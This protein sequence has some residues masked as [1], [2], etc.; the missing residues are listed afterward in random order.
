MDFATWA[1][2]HTI[3]MAVAGSRL[4]GT[5]R[6]D[7]DHDW[8][9]VCF[10]P[11]TALLGIHRFDQQ[12]LF[13]KGHDEVVYG[14]TKFLTMVL[15]ANPA[16]LDILFA[17]EDAIAHAD[18]FW[19]DIAK[20]ANGLL[21][22][23]VRHTFSG[24]AFSQLKRIKRHKVW[25]D[26]PPEKPNLDDFGLFLYSAEGGQQRFELQ[27][28]FPKGE[29]PDLTAHVASYKAAKREYDKYTS[30]RKNRN[31][32]RAKL[33]ELYGYDVK[34][35]SHLVRLLLQGE[36]ILA[37][38]TYQPR[39]VGGMRDVVLGVLHGEWDYEKLVTFAEEQEGVVKGMHSDLPR[40]PDK[41]IV[42]RLLRKAASISLL[43]DAEFAKFAR[44]ELCY[45]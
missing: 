45:D 26:N 8:R 10:D 12:E 15:A 25:I 14:A 28:P 4:Y 29:L 34:H 39:L 43:L 3:V 44:Q 33:E 41:R 16:I 2:E 20:E 7:S 6:E 19:W 32:A 9:G 13:T 40:K 30:W 42:D 38:G 35:A 37:T 17:P 24:Y 5:H 18:P 27:R 11:P 1:K 21:S 23:K 31:P 22:Q 36:E